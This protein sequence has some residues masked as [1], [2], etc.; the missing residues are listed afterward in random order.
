MG[1]VGGTQKK[2]PVSFKFSILLFPCKLEHLTLNEAMRAN[3][4]GNKRIL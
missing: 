1:G 4:H 3:L 2:D